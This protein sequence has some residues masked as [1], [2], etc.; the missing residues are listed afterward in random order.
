MK[1]NKRAWAQAAIDVEDIELGIRI[2]KMALDEGA[3]WIEVGTPLIYR[4]G[5]GAIGMLRKALGKEAVLVA[6]YKFLVPFGCM[7]HAE[8]EGADYAIFE[9]GYHT[10]LVRICME[11]AEKM[12]LIPIYCLSVHP[13]DFTYYADLYHGMG[14]RYFFTHH[15]YNV[16]DKTTRQPVRCN[17]ADAFNA[18]RGSICYGITNDEFETV[19][20]S[21]RAGAS[22]I[23]F[24]NAIH[25]PDREACRKW[26]QLIHTQESAKKC[27]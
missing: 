18:C 27:V 23:T 17:N 2:A 3:D 22:W 19:Q 20:D 12:H 9:A 10:E 16:L 13:Q 6:D 7:E 24:G 21:I 11:K 1:E 8:E 25:T 14:V 5:H 4:Y 15:Y 26:I